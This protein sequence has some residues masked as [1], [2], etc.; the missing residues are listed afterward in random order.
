MTPWWPAIC[1][2]VACPG[3]GGSDDD[4]DDGGT[5]TAPD[6]D[7]DGFLSI[8]HGG[9]DCDDDD[10]NVNPEATETW[11]DGIDQDCDGASDFDADGDR[12]DS[13]GYGGDDCD[14]E[15]EYTRPG[16]L[17]V[18]DSSRDEDCDGAVDEADC[19]LS[20][21]SALADWHDEDLQ[22]LGA[23]LAV[24]CDLDGDGQLDVLAS[25]PGDVD[26]GERGKVVRLSEGSELYES[27][28]LVVSHGELGAGLGSGL[29]CGGDLDGDGV[30]D[31]VVAS[32][33]DGVDELG[34]T[35]VF[36]GPVG[37]GLSVEEADILLWGMEGSVYYEPQGHSAEV[38][39]VTG[40]GVA[41][42][43]Y[44]QSDS[45]GPWA[46]A[47]DRIYGG[48]LAVRRGPLEDSAYWGLSG[49][50]TLGS[51]EFAEFAIGDLDADGFNDI[52][53]SGYSA[54]DKPYRCGVV[55]SGAD[56]AV[57]EDGTGFGDGYGAAARLD[58]PG[59]L[60]SPTYVWSLSAD[61]DLDDDGYGDAFLAHDAGWSAF[62]GGAGVWTDIVTP[63]AQLQSDFCGYF[64]MMSA[65]F[66]RGP[67]S[68]LA[69]ATTLHGIDC[70]RYLD[71]YSGRVALF[72]GWEWAELSLDDAVAWVAWEPDWWGLEPFL[73]GSRRVRFSHE[74][75][76]RLWFTDGAWMS[77]ST[78]GSDLDTVGG[79]VLAF[80]LDDL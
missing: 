1:L 70:E 2:L 32:Q 55:Y 47:A 69:W 74:A 56:L 43:V 12:A 21:A 41:D 63:Q 29:D 71:N 6:A 16:A 36:L 59:S 57:A 78:S 31:L 35:A 73:A 60:Y 13:D 40:D 51:G 4:D 75:A 68:S 52:L 7:G 34:R 24:D 48:A 23:A 28:V 18:C 38:A 64:G 3:K 45:Y 25:A 26:E 17:E 67:D 53:T 10:P 27:P 80:D 65:D 44:A 37:D 46:P 72:E 9:E 30:P 8:E 39:D 5:E 11:Y 66:E 61:V 14:D 76:T 15:D 77:Y 62:Q 58:C 42:I 54:T 33:D 50:L 22:F 20:P 19:G 79:R 49:A